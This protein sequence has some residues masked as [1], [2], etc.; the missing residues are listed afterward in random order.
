MPEKR[1]P[2][3]ETWD[4]D[5]I[6]DTYRDL[7]SGSIP[8]DLEMA[9]LQAVRSA[10]TG[11]SAGWRPRFRQARLRL[12]GLAATVAVVALVAVTL[13]LR[14]WMVAGPTASAAASASTAV[15]QSG[16]TAVPTSTLGRYPGGIPTTIG[17]Q[18]VYVSYAAV[19]HADD[20]TDATPFLV[21][22]WSYDYAHDRNGIECAGGSL[23]GPD[24]AR[25]TLSYS[26]PCSHGLGG[27]GPEAYGVLADLVT[28][29]WSIQTRPSSPVVLRVHTH[30]A[31]ASQCT[32]DDRSFC[33]TAIVV[34]EVVWSGDAWTQTDPVSVAQA[35]RRLTSITILKPKNS[36]ANPYP[37]FV[38]GHQSDC[39]S[40]WPH[41]VFEVRGDS[42]FGLLAVF[43][44]VASR[45]A[46]EASLDPASPGCAPDTRM[47]RPGPAVWVG[48][49]NMLALVYGDPSMVKATT[50]A[51]ATPTTS[52][53]S[54]DA[55]LPASSVSA[56]DSYAVVA[57]YELARGV[58]L[59]GVN[60]P[61]NRP[62]GASGNGDSYQPD[63]LARFRAGA[64]SFAIGPAQPATEALVGADLWTHVAPVAS[65]ARVYMVDHP[66][67]TDPALASELVLCYRADDTWVTDL[68]KAA[69]LPPVQP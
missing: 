61:V 55:E 48:V 28:L 29:G 64:L 58:A 47:V 53:R 2:D 12:A 14:P 39:P 18:P 6:R 57:D 46:A 1:G 22:M 9:T 37:L 56:E 45:Q 59:L 25:N 62:V 3:S 41:E 52:P 34:D 66:D 15:A 35:V 68:L 49:D 13:S 4:D 10:G 42:R 27:P 31:L 16:V 8:L 30:D 20:A 33:E 69:P 40:P 43:P 32:E 5:R 19:A 24:T 63:A 38:V 17:G 7:T 67:S 65:T 23:P 11:R 21:G 60:S 54:P 36:P 50:A 26:G 44:D 51:L